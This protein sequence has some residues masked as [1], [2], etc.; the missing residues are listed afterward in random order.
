MPAL[1]N[2]MIGFGLVSIPISLE[3]ATGDHDI[4]FHQ[5]HVKDGGRIRQKRICEIDGSEVPYSDL[6]KGYEQGGKKAVL[7]DDDM[8]D[9]PL[10]SKKLIDVVAF[11]D[12]AEV[13]STR[14]DRA[15]YVVPARE[16]AAKPYTLLRDTMAEHGQAAIAKVT[17][18][19]REHLALMRVKGDVMVLHTMFW[20]DEVRDAPAP[21][22]DIT[23][24]PQEVQMALSLMARI[25]EGFDLAAEVDDRQQALAELLAAKL[26]G[27]S[28]PHHMTSEPEP[29]EVT[30]LMA[31]L[32]A[33][34]EATEQE[35]VAKR[36]RGRSKRNR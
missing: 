28:L 19:T 7:T 30:D 27:A 33:S 4:R 22:S 6:A 2:G 11:I 18:G 21:A 12:A 25:S 13:D 29:A 5:V 15:Y 14:Y 36:E 1:W 16:N 8:A 9:L 20:P 26:E 23:T 31:A 35:P 34:M 17:L 10:P 32:K 24:R 3:P